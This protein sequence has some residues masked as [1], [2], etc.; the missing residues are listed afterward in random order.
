MVDKNKV[1]DEAMR[2]ESRLKPKKIFTYTVLALI[3]GGFF[4]YSVIYNY[5]RV[6]FSKELA[7]VIQ[8]VDVSTS[9]GEEQRIYQVRLEN[10]KIVEVQ[11]GIDTSIKQGAKVKV[12]RQELESGK[13]RYSIIFSL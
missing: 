7:G 4:S 10:N 6:K 8:S 9:P 3:F 13:M 12:L 2:R 1:L 5:D 11:Q